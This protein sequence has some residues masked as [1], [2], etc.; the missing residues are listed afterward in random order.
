MLYPYLMLTTAAPCGGCGGKHHQLVQVVSSQG[1]C[2]FLFFEGFII[3]FEVM[4][5]VWLLYACDFRSSF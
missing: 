3:G 5:P 1:F 4:L 2:V